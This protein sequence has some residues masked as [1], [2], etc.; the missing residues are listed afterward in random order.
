MSTIPASL[1]VEVEPS[2]LSAAGEAVNAVA[3]V[4]TSSTR[5]PIGTVASFP[6]EEAVSSYF[7]SAS[8]Q[9]TIGSVYFGGY[10]NATA[11]PASMLWTQYNQTAVPAYLRGGNISSLTLAQ[12]Q[13]INGSLDIV[14]DG[15][16]H[17]GASLNLSGVGSPTAAATQIQNAINGSLP[18]EASFTAS[19]ASGSFSVTASI[20]GYLMNVT[21]IGSGPVVIGAAISGVGVTGSP[22]I[23][24]QVSGVA[25]GIGVYAISV[26][27][28]PIASETI[29]GTYGLLTVTIDSGVI[30]VGQ[31][32]S[33]NG[34]SAGT[35]ITQL[36]G[37]S[38]GT[39]TYVVN[40]AQILGGGAMTSTPTAAVVTYDSVSGAFV[41]TSGITGTASTI[42]F[43]TGSTAASL[44]LTSATGAA[45]S[46]GAAPATPAA[47]M[48]ALTA[49]TTDWVSFMTDF[50]PDG[51]SGNTV[52]QEFAAWNTVQNDE[53]LYVCWD[54]DITPTESMPAAA[55]LGYILAQNGN[56][57]T[58]LVYEPTDLYLGAFICGMV[59]SINFNQPNG[60]IT[61][62]YKSQAG[63]TASVT[64]ATVAVN[65][66]GN[67][68]AP[69]SF[70]NGYN[71]YGAVGAANQNF[72]WFQRGTVTGPYA[73]LDS[74]VN[75]VVL[76]SALQTSLL[77]FLGSIGAVPFNNAG[78][79]LIEQALVPTIGQ[80]GDP[81]KGGFGAFGPGDI[82]AAQAAALNT[83]AGNQNASTTLETQG[84]YLQINPAP[85][86]VRASRGP[87]AITFWYLDNGSVQ[88][89][90][91][92]SV[93]VQ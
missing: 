39:G 20:S 21:A 44:L 29:S 40:N 33:G 74:Y 8:K 86:N 79:S 88:S 55:S 73:W 91:L 22:S 47:F 34:V 62:A 70:G 11:Q 28:S 51:G 50:D 52:K 14:I 15:Y 48:G 63:L 9:A 69:G 76:N 64:S 58:C 36:D 6:D 65:L 81:A 57:G 2:V 72:V 24:G 67:P 80:Y 46:Q 61:T 41:V 45:L 19:M 27:Q 66:G 56:S 90:S 87:W 92:S 93:A 13:A 53:F 49:V 89:I 35:I 4:L 1:F 82:T 68:Q 42:A 43:A 12:L 18:T 26:S 23:T 38:G 84:W 5:V 60:R 16:P 10:T 3:V 30:A 25:G 75:Q 31:T 85:A 59:A 17:N 54:T 37:G 7:G 77:A 71:Y 32:L 78:A 83:A